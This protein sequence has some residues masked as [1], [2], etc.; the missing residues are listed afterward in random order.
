MK[1]RLMLGT[2]VMLCCAAVSAAKASGMVGKPSPDFKADRCLNE[3]ADRMKTLADCKGEVILVKL[4]GVKCG[5]C[6]ASMPEVQALW[7]RYEGKGFHVFMLERQ[8][9]DEAA[10]TKVF[11]NRGLTFP[12]V[13]EGSFPFQGV[14]TLPYAY[15]IGVDGTVIFEGPNGYSAVIDEEIK[16]VKYSGSASRYGGGE[17]A[18]W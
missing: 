10:I 4:W 11:R 5:P 13:L 8:G 9:H 15:V 6:L 18:G 3:P 17:A 1:T 2:L 14:G 7:N 16:K 12:D